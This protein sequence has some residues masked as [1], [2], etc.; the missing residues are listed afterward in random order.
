MQIKFRVQIFW[1]ESDNLSLFSIS[2]L[3]SLNHPLSRPIM[4]G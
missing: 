1:N 3:V 2:R 4:N